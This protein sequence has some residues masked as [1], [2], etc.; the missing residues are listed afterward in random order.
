MI[1]G[2]QTHKSIEYIMSKCFRIKPKTALNIDYS[3]FHC[4]LLLKSKSKQ[5]FFYL[6]DIDFVES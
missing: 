1:K 6:I 4:D 5:V 2:T 3:T